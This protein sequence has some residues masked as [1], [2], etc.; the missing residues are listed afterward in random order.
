MKSRTLL[1]LL[2]LLLACGGLVAVLRSGLLSPK[3]AGRTSHAIFEKPIDHP[4]TVI[5]RDRSGAEL[6][7]HRQGGTWK[8]DRPIPA[9]ARKDKLERIIE[10]M[11][12]LEYSRYLP[13]DADGLDEEA[14]GLARPIWTVVLAGPKGRTNTLLVGTTV[15]KLGTG[16]CETFVRPADSGQTFIVKLDIPGMLIGGPEDYRQASKPQPA[17]KP[18]TRPEK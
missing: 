1:V 17:S 16:I 9:E 12:T 3:P 13:P 14:T 5:I 6:A 8:M 10:V 18:T 4:A 15:P 11:Q 7:F 2:F